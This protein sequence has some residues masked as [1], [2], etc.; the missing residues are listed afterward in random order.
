[1]IIRVIGK[2][3]AKPPGSP[4]GRALDP[5]HRLGPLSELGIRYDDAVSGTPAAEILGE[6]IVLLRFREK[7]VELSSHVAKTRFCK[8]NLGGF[9]LDNLRS[10]GLAAHAESRDARLECAIHFTN[11]KE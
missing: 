1:M 5:V 2:H 9:A 11:S 7:L 6:R 3:P 10:L 4:L 8:T